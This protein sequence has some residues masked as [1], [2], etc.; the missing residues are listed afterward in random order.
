MYFRLLASVLC[1]SLLLAG[2]GKKQEQQVA[3]VERSTRITV[4]V[5]E[6]RQVEVIERSV[7]VIESEGAPTL[8]AEIAGQVTRVL[9]DVGAVVR[10][11]E[12]RKSVV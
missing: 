2:C 11:G 3:P 8:N 7:G 5:A 9:V 10:K 1:V 12:D 6:Q 4:A